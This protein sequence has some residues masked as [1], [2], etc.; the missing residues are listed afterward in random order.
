[1]FQFLFVCLLGL[2]IVCSVSNAQ[3][4]IEFLNGSSMDCT[5][6]QIR[7]DAME[8]DIEFK[9]G[10]KRIK[11]TYPYSKVHAVIFKGKRFELTPR[12]TA[13]PAER[14]LDLP[15]RTRSEVLELI[16]SAGQAP[17][18]WFATTELDAP[19]TLELNWP[20]KAEEGWNNKKNVGQYIWDIV[21]PNEHRWHA[22]IKLVHHCMSLHKN[23]RVLLKRDMDK[24]G[25]MYFT[26]LQDYARAAFWFQ[27]AGVQASDPSGIFLAE[28]YWRLGNKEMSLAMM[29][30]KSLS[31]R[32]IKLLGDMGE[33]KDALQV[34]NLYATSKVAD[35][36][37]LA[38]GDA[39][40]GAQRFDEAVEYY[41]RVVDSKAAKNE[42]YAKRYKARARESIEA[43]QTIDKANVSRVADGSYRDAST[44]Y[45]GPVEVE[46]IVVSGKIHTLKV[47]RHT[48]KQFYAALIDTPRQIL[49]RQSILD[50][51]GTSG[52]TITSQAIVLAT[53]RALAQGAQ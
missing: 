37:F 32:S 14:N 17:P 50:I 52:A 11:Q 21:N 1:M 39:L 35:E 2:G 23:D 19:A 20:L 53:A 18:D 47:I 41:Q 30:G 48:E 16:N 10:D 36:A 45:N 43:V 15:L 5:I 26:L 25:T 3:D 12:T 34:A 4:T 28:C 31:V 6:L 13:L 24:L 40:R 49:E 8:F 51:D 9:L 7:K 46:L 42:E 29:K 44:G 33:I 22:G 38:A 27:K